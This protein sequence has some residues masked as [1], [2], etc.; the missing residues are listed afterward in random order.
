MSCIAIYGLFPKSDYMEHLSRGEGYIYQRRSVNSS[1]FTAASKMKLPLHLLLLALFAFATCRGDGL[2]DDRNAAIRNAKECFVDGPM[3]R[4]WFFAAQLT[5]L[6]K[7]ETAIR[8][9]EDGFKKDLTMG[10]DCICEFCGH[11]VM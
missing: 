2:E 11:N 9:C 7:K 3:S 5:K 10:F 6:C 4:A 8:I 1:S